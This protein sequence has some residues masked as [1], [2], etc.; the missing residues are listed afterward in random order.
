MYI[1]S[2]APLDERSV[3]RFD[4]LNA[5]KFKFQELASNEYICS[6]EGHVVAIAM[7]RNIVS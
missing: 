6:V 2:V 3:D 4:A 5:T 1:A 7:H